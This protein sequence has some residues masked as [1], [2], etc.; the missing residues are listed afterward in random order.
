MKMQDWI[1]KIELRERKREINIKYP[2]DGRNKKI[3]FK[4]P[5]FKNV[6]DWKRKRGRIKMIRKRQESIISIEI[7]KPQEGKIKRKKGRDEKLEK[8]RGENNINNNNNNNKKNSGQNFSFF[9]KIKVVS[10]VDLEQV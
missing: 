10:R 8:L 3:L 7:S 1:T 9:D 2:M 4:D 6:K 5:S